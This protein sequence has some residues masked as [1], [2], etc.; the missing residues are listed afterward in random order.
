MCVLVYDESIPQPMSDTRHA[1]MNVRRQK[2]NFIHTH[3]RVRARSTHTHTHTHTHHSHTPFTPSPARACAR[4]STTASAGMDQTGSTCAGQ[5]YV[6]HTHTHRMCLHT[7]TE[8][9]IR[10]TPRRSQRTCRGGSV[11]RSLP[12]CLPQPAM[13]RTTTLNLHVTRCVTWRVMRC[14]HLHDALHWRAA[15]G[16]PGLQI[17]RARARRGRVTTVC[18]RVFV[19]VCV[20]VCLGVRVCAPACVPSV[21]PL[22]VR[23]RARGRCQARARLART[24]RRGVD[25]ARRALARGT[26][27][28]A[29][30]HLNRY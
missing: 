23:A 25:G 8:H 11:Q 28:H 7:G 1:D 2:H 12:P 26:A 24:A 5:I 10:A 21:L 22:R 16:G 6:G 3:T 18:A 15:V 17:T 9:S 14:A 19:C 20:C 13:C 29:R 4:T 27:R 30:A